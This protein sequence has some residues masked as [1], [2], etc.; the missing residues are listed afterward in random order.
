VGVARS[1]PVCDD[2][3]PAPRFFRILAA[4]FRSA[5]MER[6]GIAEVLERTAEI[7]EGAPMNAVEAN[8]ALGRL[9]ARER[10]VS[11][12]SEATKS[13]QPKSRPRRCTPLSPDDERHYRRMLEVKAARSGS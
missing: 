9:L 4:C 10:R 8:R 1:S 2:V 13:W 11:I 12:Y 3:D 7:L 6:R 5:E